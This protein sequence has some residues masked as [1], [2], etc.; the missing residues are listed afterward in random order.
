MAKK[1][2][3]AKAETAKAKT[4]E[5]KTAKVEPAEPKPAKAKGAKAKTA[6]AKTAKAEAAAQPSDSQVIIHGIAEVVRL[7]LAAMDPESRAALLGALVKVGSSLA[8]S[9]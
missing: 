3:T 7:G 8:S 5:P 1:A 9:R 6:K 4:A 2:K